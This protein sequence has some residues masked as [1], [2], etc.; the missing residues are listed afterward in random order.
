MPI[1]TAL[2]LAAGRGTR[3]GALTRHEPK[4]LVRVGEEPI[5]SRL[6]RQLVDAGVEEIVIVVGHLGHLIMR[7]LG[8]SC[9]GRPIRYVGSDDFATTNNVTSLALASAYRRP[10]LICDCDIVLERLPPDWLSDAGYDLAVPVR[11]LAEGET[12][13]VLVTNGDGWDMRMRRDPGPPDPAMR[14]SLSLYLV[15]NTDLIAAIYDGCL[16]AIHDNDLDLYYEDIIVR[17]AA[18]FSMVAIDTD[19]ARFRSFEIDTP[20]DLRRAED[21]LRTLDDGDEAR[22]PDQVDGR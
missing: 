11:R 8:P 17:V 12:G 4:A 9:C 10:I 3:L 20:L 7:A 2:I 16:A 5:I 6:C 1:A 18:P 14:K 19:I 15:F 21:A 22:R 13:C